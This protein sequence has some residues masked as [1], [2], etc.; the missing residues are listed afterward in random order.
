MTD[1]NDHKAESIWAAM[2]PK[3][4]KMVAEG[5]DYFVITSDSTSAQ[6]RCSVE[7]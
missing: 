2:M 5:V 7:R 4:E 1:Q 6:Y 3:L